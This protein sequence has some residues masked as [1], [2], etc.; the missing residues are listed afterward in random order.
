MFGIKNYFSFFCPFSFICTSIASVSFFTLPTRI[1]AITYSHKVNQPSIQK[2]PAKALPDNAIALR[3]SARNIAQN[4]INF[5]LLIGEWAEKGKCNSYRLVF[6][7]DGIY[8]RVD[9]KQRRWITS[10]K[11]FYVTRHPNV[12]GIGDK[13]NNIYTDIYIIT[14]SKLTSKILTGTGVDEDEINGKETSESWVRCPNS[15]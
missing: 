12:I 7:Q 5:S 4:S 10:F 1:D 8:K 14:V 11:G 6:T 13:S 15:K 3:F 9:K 2:L